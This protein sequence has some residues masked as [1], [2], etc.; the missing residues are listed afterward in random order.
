[1]QIDP[2]FAAAYTNRAL[3]YR[4]IDKD[5]LALADFNAAIAANPNDAAAYLGRGN[6]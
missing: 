2:H 5:G 1:M 3:A 6:L 4:Q